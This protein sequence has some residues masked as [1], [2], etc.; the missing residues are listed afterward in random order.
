MRAN[1]GTRTGGEILVD[2]LVAHG[3]QHVFCVPGES[4]LA[5]LDAFYDRPIQLTV[6]RQEGGATMMA[7]AQGKA[8][9]RPGI[10]SSRAGRARP[11][12]RPASTSRSR[13]R[14]R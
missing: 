7:E 4:Y 14:R 11:M 6:C 2:Q 12:P 9:G 1:D 5:A 8:T 13:I 10:C 3:V